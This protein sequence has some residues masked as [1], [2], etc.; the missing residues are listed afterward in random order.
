MG[1]DLR[2]GHAGVGGGA[3]ACETGELT[4]AGGLDARADIGG[5][6]GGLLGAEF[7]DGECGS[8]DVQVDAVEKRTADTGAV[9]LDL[10]G[11]AAA[12]VF[13][14]AE[15]AA[16]AWILVVWVSHS[17]ELQDLM[18]NLAYSYAR[19]SSVGQVT[20]SGIDR[21][22]EKAR[23]YCRDNG[24]TF[25][26]DTFSDK[27]KSAFKS[28]HRSKD[29]ELTRFIDAVSKGIVKKGSVLI[30]EALDR[31]SREE[32]ETAITLFRSI[33][34]MGIDVVTLSDNKRYTH[35]SD[36]TMIDW[37][38]SIVHFE[39]ANAYSKNLSNRVGNAWKK[40]Q[41]TGNKNKPSYPSW[42]DYNK[43][44]DKF[45][46][47][48]EKADIVRR[49][50]T[51]YNKGSGYGKIVKSLND[52]GIKTMTGKTWSHVN[53][54]FLLLSPSV[55]GEYRPKTRGKNGE[56]VPTDIIH[57]NY[58]PAIISETDFYKAASRLKSNPAKEGRPQKEGLNL[59]DGLFKCGYCGSSM[60]VL[61][62][63][64]LIC[65]KSIS[66]ND[67]ARHA[68]PYAEFEL[69]LLLELKE[70]TDERKQEINMPVR[71]EIEAL[72]G[73]VTEITTRIERQTVLAE[74]LDDPTDSL[75][76]INVLS[77]ERTAIQNEIK[78]KTAL[79][80][81]LSTVGN[82]SIDLDILI[83][84]SRNPSERLEIQRL[85]RN[86][87]ER[88][89]VFPA[90]DPKINEAFIKDR[91]RMTEEGKGIH[92]VNKLLA[93]KYGIGKS[94]YMEIHTKNPVERKGKKV[95]SFRVKVEALAPT[96]EQIE[97]YENLERTN[98]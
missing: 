4:L 87:V 74:K 9:A 3:R 68:W 76:R 1:A 71:D 13:R 56:K 39:A 95:S 77:K 23:T 46:V 54:K 40:K 58:Y 25:S 7:V 36:S 31:L 6:F 73:K 52:D 84:G 20:G 21:Q 61:S 60:G 51:E 75:K 89:E 53:V 24:L 98:P 83:D 80:E 57:K 43:K 29:S 30:V 66:S 26:E 82:M 94:R 18:S 64:N 45:T 86:T 32:M 34:K 91:K 72:N 10:R 22:I 14:V 81:E 37:I 33:L 78:E 63:K 12:F 55:I 47:I 42:L 97:A 92:V 17:G 69:P 28:K 96:L 27:G 5:R 85:M 35:H 16:G 15:V 49:I 65:W 62:G 79:M 88:I 8:F 90:G 11:G 48:E 2:V 93:R 44:T 41:E 19:V 50:F 59:W 38:T 67:C 70:V